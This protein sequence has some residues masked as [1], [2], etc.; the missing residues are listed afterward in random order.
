MFEWTFEGVMIY[1]IFLSYM[2]VFV[3]CFLLVLV[4]LSKIRFARAR[5][6]PQTFYASFQS[7]LLLIFCALT[8]CLDE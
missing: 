8:L 7:C 6:N 2:L 5:G 4:L 3:F 1:G